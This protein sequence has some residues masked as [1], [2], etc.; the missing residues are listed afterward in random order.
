MNMTDRETDLPAP[1][2]LGRPARPA[3][4]EKAL[5]AIVATTRREWMS[6]EPAPPAPDDTVVKRARLAHPLV[7]FA[8]DA[9][10]STVWRARIGR[11]AWIRSVVQFAEL[12][13][14]PES[15]S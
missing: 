14:T 1:E 2:R 7:R 9:K 11:Q 12:E 6:Q 3:D 15:S 13:R 8:L 5:A 10:R 4:I